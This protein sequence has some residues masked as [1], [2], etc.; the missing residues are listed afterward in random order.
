MTSGVSLARRKVELTSPTSIAKF[1]PNPVF[2]STVANFE[3]SAAY[4]MFCEAVGWV[5]SCKSSGINSSR[6]ICK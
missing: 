4:R 6:M 5:D 1:L 2:M 3:V